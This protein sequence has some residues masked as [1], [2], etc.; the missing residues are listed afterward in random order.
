MIQKENTMASTI[1]HPVSVQYD[2]YQWEFWQN[3]YPVYDR[4]RA[5][6]PVH[7][8]PLLG[9]WV[10]SNHASVKFAL[11]DTGIQ[12][13]DL[14]SSIENHAQAQKRHLPAIQNALDAT[15]FLQTPP[16]HAAARRYLARVLNARPLGDYKP[17]VERISKQLFAKGLRQGGMD[18]VR[19]YSDRL[20]FLFMAELL[21][22]PESDVPFLMDCCDR[23]VV[24]L[25]RRQC[26]PSEYIELN[27]QIALGLDHL[28][29]LFRERRRQ[30]RAD[31]LSRMIELTLQE[32]ALTNRELAA[33]CYF[34]FMVGV[35]T[36][37]TFFGGA[38]LTLLEHPEESARWR[39]GEVNTE[40]AIE[41]LLRYVTPVQA[42][43]RTV[44]EDREIFGREL[45]A[46][47]RICTLL[48][49]ANRDETLF[50]DPNQLDLGRAPSSHLAFGDG[51]HVCLGAA[52]ARMEAVIGLRHFLELP[53][54]HRTEPRC[55]W[56][57]YEMIR[58]LKRLPV[59][60]VGE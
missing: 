30:P 46:G 34:I 28:E 26:S 43:L 6:D 52:L 54:M 36:T 19:E 37:V 7:W 60:F 11:R 24:A 56:W 45:K 1:H 15:L 22:V 58:K 4:L 50:P 23:V 14:S 5:D 18:L 13:A 59:E 49:S 8:E 27:S 42:T 40:G 16:G 44:I 2:P 38:L 12:P 35:E 29:S 32:T 48:G 51:P 55:E 57:P 33:R 3:P 10:L 21:G 47:Q 17:I 53:G 20:P 25:F 41:E 31:G 9:E 39:Q